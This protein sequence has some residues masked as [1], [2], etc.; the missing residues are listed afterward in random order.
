MVERPILAEPFE[1]VAIDLV[2]P[3]PKGKGGNRYILTY[4]CLATRWPEAEPLRSITA[5][6]VMDGLW[7]IF[8]RTSVPERILTDQG[9]QFCGKVMTQLCEHLGI[10]KYERPPTTPRQTVP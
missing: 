10:E 4:I 6:A 9:S 1:S 8:S 2:G 5:K 7:S 3:L